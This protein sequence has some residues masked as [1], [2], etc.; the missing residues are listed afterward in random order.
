MVGVLEV[1]SR[2]TRRQ[3]AQGCPKLG[4][5]QADPAREAG[6]RQRPATMRDPA[7]Q[8]YDDRPLFPGTRV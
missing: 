8:A 2:I 4:P 1:R 7:G 6:G 5:S 3:G